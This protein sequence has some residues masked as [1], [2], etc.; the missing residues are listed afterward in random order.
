MIFVKQ[1]IPLT[2]KIICKSNVY[3]IIFLS[4]YFVKNYLW[5]LS[6]NEVGPASPLFF[7]HSVARSFTGIHTRF[8]FSTPILPCQRFT[9]FCK[10][11]IR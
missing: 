11:S 8:Q 7:Y 3:L 1:D 2:E 4:A 6:T 10:D 9:I 5:H